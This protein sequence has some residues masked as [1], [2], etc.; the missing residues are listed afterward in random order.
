MTR[1]RETRFIRG[2]YHPEDA[3]GDG[4]W[5]PGR[6]GVLVWQPNHTSADD[7]DTPPVEERQ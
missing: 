6:W 3:L 2:G 7:G 4:R 5:V 1:V